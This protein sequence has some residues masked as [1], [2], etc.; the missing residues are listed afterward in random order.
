MTEKEYFEIGFVVFISLYT[1]RL[2]SYI[3]KGII[4]DILLDVLFLTY[5]VIAISIFWYPVMFYLLF[6]RGISAFFYLVDMSI[7]LSDYIKE[8]IG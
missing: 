4:G 1:I 7:K 5:K 8:R 3:E 2:Y 6:T